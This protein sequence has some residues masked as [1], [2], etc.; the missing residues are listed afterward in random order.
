MDEVFKSLKITTYNK[1]DRSY[2]VG[3]TLFKLNASSL[4]KDLTAKNQD[5]KSNKPKLKQEVET[6]EEINELTQE[7]DTSEL[8]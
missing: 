3:T 6:I 2:L 4:I 1:Y 7:Y 5:K 8:D